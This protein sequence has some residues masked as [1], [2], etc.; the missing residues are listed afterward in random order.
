M[1]SK[2]AWWTGKLDYTLER[3]VY[4]LLSGPRRCL[5]TVVSLFLPSYEVNLAN[6]PLIAP[7]ARLFLF[8][9]ASVT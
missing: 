9:G 2:L 1:L 3:A 8:A 7:L 6:I 4:L 5:V